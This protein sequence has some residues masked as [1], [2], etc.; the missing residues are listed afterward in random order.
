MTPGLRGLGAIV[1]ALSVVLSGCKGGGG[2]GSENSPATTSSTSG[3]AAPT[4]SGSAAAVAKANAAYSFA[5]QAS[6]ADGDAVS[7]QIENKPAWA[8][9]NTVTGELTGTPTNAQ[10]GTYADIVISASDGKHVVSL[11]AFKIAVD[12][13]VASTVQL[14]WSA[15]TENI[16][17]SALTD[18]GGFIIAYGTSKS[19]LSQT[20]HIENP[21][22]DRYVITDLAPGT[23][24]FGV[25]AFSRDGV[26]SALSS[27][28]KKTIK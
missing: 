17:G 11:P 7:F 8:S 21:S 9:F 18:L 23:Y 16:D 2:G 6:D 28:V 13:N 26:E 24:Y 4:L 19:A 3:N 25:K 22:V 14:S 27:L 10:V 12:G 15:P 5:P 20:V 1:C